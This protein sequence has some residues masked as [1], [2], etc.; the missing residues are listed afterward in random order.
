MLIIMKLFSKIL[1]GLMAFSFL[2]GASAQGTDTL[3]PALVYPK[4]G[5]R[6]GLF[7]IVGG[8]DRAI[9]YKTLAT[10]QGDTTISTSDV[11]YYFLESVDFRTALD[12]YNNRKYA[13]AIKAFQAVQNKYKN[14]REVPYNYAAL[15]E[16]YIAQCE[17]RLMNTGAMART[18]TAFLKKVLPWSAVTNQLAIFDLWKIAES[19]D[20]KKL[21][22]QASKLR[23]RGLGKLTRE[24]I[25]QVDYLLGLAY[26][27]QDKKMEALASLTEAMVV[28]STASIEITREA[29][30]RC[31]E[32]Y[33]SDKEVQA[34]MKSHPAGPFG[35]VPL[36]IREGA[37]LMY[38]WKNVMF[39]S[40]EV[41]KKYENFLRYYQAPPKPVKKED[42]AAE[43]KPAEQPA[44]AA[45]AE[46]KK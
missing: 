35:N 18:D 7:Y 33:A 40:P 15:A 43:A 17:R 27:R 19:K 5:G 24:E 46:E 6:G 14:V 38:V 28:D 9:K 2:G 31:M 41:P 4:N 39:I 20:W 16:F 34:Y 29:M 42:K 10:E 8:D 36:F 1:C 44:P 22:A 37:A 25:V 12:T 3:V 45:P 21:Q 11:R 32:I 13:E 26:Q 23:D 30:L